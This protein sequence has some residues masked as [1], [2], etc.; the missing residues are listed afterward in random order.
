MMKKKI[1][2][3]QNE[4]YTNKNDIKFF[5]AC[6]LIPGMLLLYIL[7]HLNRLGFFLNA[8]L[9]PIECVEFIN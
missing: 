8:I 5:S 4:F 7:R 2:H 1:K 3:I 6:F 9:K